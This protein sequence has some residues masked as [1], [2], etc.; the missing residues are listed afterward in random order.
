MW[1][2]AIA[3]LLAGLFLSVFLS[4]CNRNA[5]IDLT[6]C[7]DHWNAAYR[8]EVGDEPIITMDQIREWKDWCVD[9]KKPSTL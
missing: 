3:I 6:T 8:Q 4:K 9:G 1:K 7:V 5:D 2:K